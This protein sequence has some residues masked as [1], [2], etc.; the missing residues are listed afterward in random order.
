MGDAKFSKSCFL[1]GVVCLFLLL[2]GRV[3]ANSSPILKIQENTSRTGSA[4]D[5]G[6]RVLRWTIP[7]GVPSTLYLTTLPNAVCTIHG[8]GS[9]D[10][11]DDA[12]EHARSDDEQTGAKTQK[13]VAP[14]EGRISFQVQPPAEESDIHLKLVVACEGTDVTDWHRIV[15]RASLTPTPEMPAPT[16]PDP[17]PKERT[18]KILPALTNCVRQAIYC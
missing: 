8:P 11:E 16:A 13:L 9:L 5:K 10:H 18:Y 7:P 6:A 4:D 3:G 17:S 12:Q 15:L 2:C 1:A 14:S